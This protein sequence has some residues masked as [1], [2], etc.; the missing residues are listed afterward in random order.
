MRWIP[1]PTGQDG[2]AFRRI[3]ARKDGAEIYAAWILI[4]QI[5]ARMPVRGILADQDGDLVPEDFA[6]M[7]GYPEKLFKNA[8]SVLCSEK[9]GWLREAS[10]KHPD[11]IP[12]PSRLQDITGQDNTGQNI[13]GQ[14]SPSGEDPE[15]PIN[16]KASASKAFYD[17][18]FS[19]F[20]SIY[21]KRRGKIVGKQKA[22]EYF[23][24]LDPDDLPKVIANAK[25]YGINN[26]LPKDPE[27]FLKNDFWRD[28]DTPQEA[29]KPKS[30]GFLTAGEKQDIETDKIRA[31]IGKKR[32][33]GAL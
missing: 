16:D 4:L 26:D 27:R 30:G 18:G 8:V 6:L 19:A 7:S 11:D 20:W 2:K 1:I 14:D 17:N 24:R 15:Y 21:P 23:G 33:R 32:I 22:R 9:I 25:N 3:A 13:T 29:D 12:I 28:W 10:G 5:A 31:S